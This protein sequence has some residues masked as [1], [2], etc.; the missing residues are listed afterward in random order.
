MGKS[1]RKALKSGPI[2]MQ[3]AQQYFEGFKDAKYNELFNGILGGVYAAAKFKEWA[4]DPN[5]VGIMFWYSFENETKKYLLAAEKKITPFDYEE[6]IIESYKPEDSEIILSNNIITEFGP[7]KWIPFQNE[8]EFKVDVIKPNFPDKIENSA[9]IEILQKDFLGFNKGKNISKVSFAFMCK[10]DS[11]EN[12]KSYLID[13]LTD[14]KL[15]YISYHFGY[16][17]ALDPHGLRLVLMGR[18]HD[19]RI[20]ENGQGKFKYRMEN[21]SKPPRKPPTQ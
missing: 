1:K 11:D 17:S 5:F 6:D 8:E 16:S 21:E 3:V 13:F 18:D 20:I 19:G 4:N 14:P 9:K 7:L 2:E 10:A 15:V 12:G